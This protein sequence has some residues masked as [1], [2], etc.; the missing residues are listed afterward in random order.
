MAVTILPRAAAQP[1]RPS[2]VEIDLTRLY[3]AHV[4]AHDWRGTEVTAFVEASSHHAA[5]KKIAAAIAVLENRKPE[6]VL[7]RIYNCS[8]AEELIAEGLSEDHSVR[9]L[10]T[11]WSGGQATHFVRSPLVLTANPAVL[12]RIWAQLQR[13]S[14]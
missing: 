14:P 9:L 6:D 10:E 2:P 13:V 11:G 8:S 12:L 7:D 5:A 3:R 1:T 4:S